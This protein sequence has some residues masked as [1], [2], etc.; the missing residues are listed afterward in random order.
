MRRSV[1]EQKT[2]TERQLCLY[3]KTYLSIFLKN[4]HPL[5]G[6]CLVSVTDVNCQQVLYLLVLFRLCKEG[7][8]VYFFSS[9]PLALMIHIPGDQVWHMLM[10]AGFI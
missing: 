5:S 6:I 9:V 2:A 10:N 1:T 7:F 8:V 3:L 4:I